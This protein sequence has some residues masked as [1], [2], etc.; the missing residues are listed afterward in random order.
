MDE[1][2]L[3]AGAVKYNEPGQAFVDNLIN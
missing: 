3:Q 2:A 1:N